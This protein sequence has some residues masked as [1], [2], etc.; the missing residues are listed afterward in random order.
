MSVVS[1][2]ISQ[3]LRINYAAKSCGAKVVASNPEMENANH[4]LTVNR[5]EYMLNPCSAKKW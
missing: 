5:D 2:A 3:K 4:M 1:P